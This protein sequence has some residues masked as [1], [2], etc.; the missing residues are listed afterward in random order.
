MTVTIENA[1]KEATGGQEAQNLTQDQINK[2]TKFG[3]GAAKL[4]AGLAVPSTGSGSEFYDVYEYC[5]T[6]FAVAFARAGFNAT[7]ATRETEFEE[8]KQLGGKIFTQ[9]KKAGL[10]E[11]DLL[12]EVGDFETY[13]LNPTGVI[14]YGARTRFGTNQINADDL[15]SL[16]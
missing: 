8:G 7:R 3:F 12:I 5:A 4:Y 13:P 11:S 1:I 2:A 14:T 9:L 10:I 6:L 15:S 16:R